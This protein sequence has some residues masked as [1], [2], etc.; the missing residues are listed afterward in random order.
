MNAVTRLADFDDPAFDPFKSE[1]LMLGELLD[2]YSN[3]AE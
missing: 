1:E 3:L 2:P